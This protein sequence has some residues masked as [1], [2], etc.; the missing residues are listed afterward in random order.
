MNKEEL[1]QYI[2]DNIYENQD[3]EITGEALNEVLKAIV[4]DGGTEVEANPEEA[5]SAIILDALRVGEQVYMIPTP[6]DVDTQLSDTSVN[7][8]QNKVVKQALDGKANTSSLAAKQDTLVSGTNIKTINQNSLLG[9]G[10]IT[11][12]GGGTEVEANPTGEATATLSKI[13]IGETVYTAPQGPQGP[14]GETGATGPQ[15]EQGP[16]GETGATGPQGATGPANTLTIGAVADGEEADASITGNAPNQTL[17]LILPIGKS[18]YKIAVENGFVGDEEAWLASLKANI[19]AFKFVANVPA[20]ESE[21]ED[22]TTGGVGTIYAQSIDGISAGQNTLSVI[23]LMNTISATPAKTYMIA[24]QEVTPATTPASYEFVYAG[25]LQSAM[26]SNVL[27]RGNIINDL[28]TGGT[29]D[30]LSAEQGKVLGDVVD[31]LNGKEI[32]LFNAGAY[33][34]WISNRYIV[35]SN[36]LLNASNGYSVTDFIDIAAYQ[37]LKSIVNISTSQLSGACIAF[38]DENKNYLSTCVHGTVGTQIGHQNVIADI[39]NGAKYARFGCSDTEKNSWFLT[40]VITAKSSLTDTVVGAYKTRLTNN[41]IVSGKYRNIFG[42][43]ANSAALCYSLP[44]KVSCGDKVVLLNALLPDTCAFITRVSELGEYISILKIGES[45]N[46]LTDYEIEIDFDG[47]ISVTADL[48]EYKMLYIL[49]AKIHNVI[50]DSKAALNAEVESLITSVEGLAQIV[51]EPPIDLTNA[52]ITSG[53]YRTTSGGLA[54]LSGYCYSKPFLVKKG[55]RII[56]T[57]AIE[58]VSA[59]SVISEVNSENG[60]IR[61]L[62]AGTGNAHTYN[63]E[64]EQDCY[65]GLSFLVAQLAKFRIV[66]PNLKDEVDNFSEAAIKVESKTKLLALGASNPLQTIIRECGYGC[67]LK[68]WGFIGDSYTSG[69]TPAYDGSTLKYLDCYKWSWGQQFMKIIGSEGYNFSNGGQTA[70][71]WLRSQ[72]VV[73]DES[74]YGGVGGGDWRQAQE[75]DNLKQG[76]IISLGINDKSYFGQ[77]Y[78]GATYSLGDAT[79]DVNVSDYT[80]NNENTFAGCY[81]GIIQRLLSVQPKAKIFCITQFQD[82]LEE[83][84][85]VVRDIVALFPNNVFLI[86][87]HNYALDI[88]EESYYMSNGHPTPLGYAYMAACINTYIDY[89]IRNNKQKFMDVTLIGSNYTLQ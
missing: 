77:T 29:T 26:P 27:T 17:N 36:G 57:E 32:V 64:V 42:G 33:N 25:D 88:T 60:Y 19:G 44:I 35:S 30:V 2:D 9:S 43:I 67:L 85:D 12:E 31:E 51:A 68:T 40:G 58:L 5:P 52:D 14:Q 71:G 55:T 59:V 78:L 83:I 18:A 16:Q 4:D 1:K 86:D 20:V 53:Y 39:P 10:D 23:L 70:K 75:Q 80:Q 13:K 34:N 74:Y 47:Y 50:E 21:F 63:Y 87:L 79:T 7:P 3:G 37:Q 15:G 69:E 8:V 11:I 89:I 65:I 22:A 84:N 54:S 46:V 41:D 61:T 49:K 48:L 45:S 24:T 28:T 76:Y 62:K 56:T 38:Y 73:R 6:L 72:G 81:A 66:V 82:N